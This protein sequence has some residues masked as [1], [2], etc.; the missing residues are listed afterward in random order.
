LILL[1]NLVNHILDVAQVLI[2][3]N[4]KSQYSVYFIPPSNSSLFVPIKLTSF[5]SIFQAFFVKLK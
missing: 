5:F 1:S 4:F 2:F 3:S